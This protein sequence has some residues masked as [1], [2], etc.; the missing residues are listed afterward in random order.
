MLFDVDM[1]MNYVFFNLLV[2]KF[3]VH[4]SPL[5]SALIPILG[6]QNELQG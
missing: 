5:I 2:G 4:I 3:V 6:Q 1:G